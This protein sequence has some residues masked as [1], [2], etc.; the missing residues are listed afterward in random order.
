MANIYVPVGR[1]LFQS[2]GEEGAWGGLP[3]TTA[4]ARATCL[5]TLRNSNR[6]H[7]S[8]WFNFEPV[9]PVRTDLFT[10]QMILKSQPVYP[11]KIDFVAMVQ[12]CL[13]KMS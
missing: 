11:V 8:F 13:L 12:F 6:R 1:A 4:L 9:S 7:Y 5:A 3:S 10:R 2:N